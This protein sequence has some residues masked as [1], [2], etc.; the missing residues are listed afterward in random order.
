MSVRTVV[1]FLDFSDMYGANQLKKAALTFISLNLADL[2]EGGYL[3]DLNRALADDITVFY[4]NMVLHSV[5]FLLVVC[6]CHVASA[7]L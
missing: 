4:R 5:V 2:V 6:S 3:K 7:I 1:E